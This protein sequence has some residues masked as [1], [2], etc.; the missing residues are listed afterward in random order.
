[1]KLPF[2]SNKGISFINALFTSTSA[3]CVT[4]LTVLDTGKDFTLFG[5][6]IIL[7][8]I[9]IGGL[10]IM[11]FSVLFLLFLKD[12]MPWNAKIAI[13][14][15]YSDKY[16]DLKYLIKS[17]IAVTAVVETVG[18][19]FLFI[20]FYFNGFSLKK[21]LFTSV[22]HSVSAFCNAGFSLFSNS[23]I[24]YQGSWFVNLVIMFL[25]ISGGIGFTVFL[26]IKRKKLSLH[27]KIV[28]TVSGILILLGACAI[29]FA[30]YSNALSGYDLNRKIAVSLF[31]S[32]TTRTAGFN[33]ID[34]NRLKDFSLIVIM[35]LMFIGASPGSCGGGVKTTTFT[36]FLLTLVSTARGRDFINIFKRTIPK[37]IIFKSFAIMLISVSTLITGIL[38][39][40]YF[41]PTPMNRFDFLSSTF[42][43]FSALGTVGLSMGYTH[44]LTM[45]GKIVI[46]FLMYIG[47][48]GP[49][50]LLLGL[51]YGSKKKM[52][53]YAEENV[54]LG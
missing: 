7:F 29:F 51:R 37:E 14:T 10:G 25:I 12:K 26:D 19:L 15:T 20:Y 27:S 47:R 49:L 39:L 32:V 5:Q 34:L 45:G 11:T 22:F 6:I 48:V 42:E 4:G 8:L 23:L 38:A 1:M 24:N 46:I 2:A 9:Q 36:V 52:I 18:A 21:A 13:K 54:M 50:T 43:A 41:D 35:M 33:T 17:I 40:A 53:Q 44:K 16:F 30:E 31:Q 28:L 3:I